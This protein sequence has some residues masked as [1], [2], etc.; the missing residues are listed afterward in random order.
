MHAIIR[1][2]TSPHIN[3][4][5][6]PW[7]FY[8]KR[9]QFFTALWSGHTAV[10]VTSRS[11]VISVHLVLSSFLSHKHFITGNFPSRS[12]TKK[13]TSISNVICTACRWKS[14][15][16]NIE[17]AQHPAVGK[18]WCEHAR[19]DCRRDQQPRKFGDATKD[20]RIGWITGVVFSDTS[21][22]RKYQ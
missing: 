7:C 15:Y 20:I 4:F 9:K 2:V 6:I 8:E 5:K 21:K 14:N 3:P 1:P 12:S 13:T 17:P 11:T 16:F 18:K 22:P 19:R 10:L